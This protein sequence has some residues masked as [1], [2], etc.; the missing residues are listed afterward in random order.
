MMFEQY[1]E[2]QYIKY[3]EARS[4]FITHFEKLIQVEKY[5]MDVLS[6]FIELNHDEIIRDY[7]E[8]S[9]LHPFWQ[10]YP[11]DDR[12]RSPIGDQY[13]WIEVGEHIFCP[14]L[15]RFLSESYCVRDC[16]IP[17]GPDERYIISSTEIKSILEITSSIWLFVDIKSVGPRDDQD[18]TVM[19]HNQISGSGKWTNKRTGVKNDII[20]AQGIRATHPF[21]CA[22]PPLYV[23]SDE[24]IVPVVHVVLKP[25]YKMLG[26]TQKC[27][28]QPLSK[29]TLVSIPNGILLAENP[30]YLKSFPSLFFPGK[31]KKEKDPRKLRARIRF[32][33]IRLIADW[34]YKN[35]DF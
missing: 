32:E 24:T 35:F 16:G 13:P 21:H 27:N 17:T 9:F 8:A 20:D 10:N 2:M 14:K 29:V 18:H 33:I 6:R 31:D 23:L 5:C 11:P 26:L 12:G 28:G 1:R 34:R 7:N 19:S 3:N 30:N 25:I 4:F 22:I 15:S